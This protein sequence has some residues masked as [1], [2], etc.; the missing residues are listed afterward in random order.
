VRRNNRAF[1]LCQPQAIQV[2]VDGCLKAILVKVAVGSTQHQVSNEVNGIGV[3][4]D[5]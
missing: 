4:E 1:L 3:K 2:V 5:R